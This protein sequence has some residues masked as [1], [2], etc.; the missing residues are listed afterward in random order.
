MR[1]CL[2]DVVVVAW[3][4]G[5]VLGVSVRS[6]GRRVC[7]RVRYGAFLCCSCGRRVCVG[8]ST[9]ARTRR[10]PL[11]RHDPLD[12]PQADEEA[13]EVIPLGEFEHAPLDFGE[14]GRVRVPPPFE[15]EGDGEAVLD[16]GAVHAGVHALDCGGMCV[17]CVC[18]CWGGGC[19]GI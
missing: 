18:L 2:F 10:Q 1:A 7:G 14:P 8:L 19:G 3:V 6:C 12:A 15:G 13:G 17:W 11:G 9:H 16:D 4:R 5:W